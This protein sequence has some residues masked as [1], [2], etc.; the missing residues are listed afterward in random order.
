MSALM[1][2]AH[3]AAMPA[4]SRRARRVD[5]GPIRMA[6]SGGESVAEPRTPALAK[7]GWGAARACI[8]AGLLALGACASLPQLTT[9]GADTFDIRYDAQKTAPDQIDAQARA[10]CNGEAALVSGG[11]GFDGLSR[12][13]YRCQNAGT[14]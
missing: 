8:A 2:I 6:N 1:P 14:N 12:R 7:L 9:T 5:P 4:A 11:V 10:H 13:S 3:G